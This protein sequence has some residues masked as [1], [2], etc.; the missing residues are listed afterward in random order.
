VSRRFAT[1]LLGLTLAGAGCSL[2]PTAQ[3]AASPCAVQFSDA[4][5]EAILVWV[6]DELGVQPDQVATIAIVPATPPPGLGRGSPVTLEVGLADG[7]SREMTISCPGVSGA[8]LPRC[9]AEPEVEFLIP[10]NEGYRDFPENATPVPPVDPAAED[11][12]IPLDLPR[13]DIPIG[14]AGEQRFVL[15]QARLANGILREVRATLADRWPDSVLLRG[16]IVLEIRP[17][18]G[19]EAITNIYQHGWQPGVEPVEVSIVFD[20][21]ILRPGA[22]LT[23]LD[24]LVR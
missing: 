10:G 15:G 17:V 12:A 8:F 22:H 21:A 3:V 24:V 6:I 20:A 9:M 4:R 2:I 5:C 19:G 1:G 23:L 11:A 18:G 16:S 7:S 13:V 14:R